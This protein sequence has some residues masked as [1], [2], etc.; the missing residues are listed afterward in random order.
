MRLGQTIMSRQSG[1]ILLLVA[2]VMIAAPPVPASN[3]LEPRASLVSDDGKPDYAPIIERKLDFYD[4]TYQ[5]VEGGPFDLRD[6]AQSKSVVIVEYLAGWCP[7]SNRNGH[8]VE[9]LWT[10]YRERG[11]GLVG[12]AEYSDASEL[13]IHIGRIGIDY[14]FVVE[15]RKRDQRKDSSH[16]KYRRAAGDKRKWGTPFYVIIDTRDIELAASKGLLA[17]RVYTVSGELVEAEADQF[18]RERVADAQRK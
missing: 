1:W 5:T 6:Y 18:I 16:Y 13:R 14:P 3:P 11:L 10:R 2:A 12:V 17:R 4:F 9:R 8:I 7:N 15:T